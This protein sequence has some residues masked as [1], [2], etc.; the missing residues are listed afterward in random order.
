[1]VFRG[2]SKMNYNL[3]TNSVNPA[4]NHSTQQ[5]C[6]SI[7]SLQLRHRLLSFLALQTPLQSLANSAASY[8]KMTWTHKTLRH[9]SHPKIYTSYIYKKETYLY[10]K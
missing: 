4:I 7:F 10:G 3:Q 5:E 8:K 9:S 1:M 6:H 2:S